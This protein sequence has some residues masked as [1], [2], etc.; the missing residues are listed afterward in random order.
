VPKR[1]ETIASIDLRWH[2]SHRGQPHLSSNGKQNWDALWSFFATL[3][4]LRHLRL[5][6]F[7]P[8]NYQLV[9]PEV[10]FDKA[11]LGPLDLLAN[12]GMEV[13]DIGIPSYFYVRFEKNHEGAPYRL[14]EIFDGT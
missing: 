5:A 10:D 1:F 11:W 14:L 3:P 6:V 2:C 7:P 12:H 4:R 9:S 8:N 13:F